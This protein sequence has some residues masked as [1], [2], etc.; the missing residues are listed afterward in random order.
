MVIRREGCG[1]SADVVV[2]SGQQSET[3]LSSL[4]AATF[5]ALSSCLALLDLLSI[6]PYQ[7]F[8]RYH[9]LRPGVQRIPPSPSPKAAYATQ[10]VPASSFR[11]A[12][13]KQAMFSDSP[14]TDIHESHKINSAEHDHQACRYENQAD[15]TISDSPI[16]ELKW[17]ERLLAC[18]LPFPPPPPSLKSAKLPHLATHVRL[19]SHLHHLPACIDSSTLLNLIQ[20]HSYSPP[21]LRSPYSPHPAHRAHRAHCCRYR[22]RQSSCSWAKHPHPASPPP[23]RLGSALRRMCRIRSSWAGW[24]GEMG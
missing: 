17:K 22:S 21:H 2:V 4:P 3:S 24:H 15:T 5:G 1:E 20:A 18:P 9:T 7:Y 19:P 8:L 10:N 12:K 14:W 13:Q 16:C 23:Q 6:A 11:Q